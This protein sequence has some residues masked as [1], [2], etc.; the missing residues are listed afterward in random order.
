[1]QPAA[2]AGATFSVIWW[3]GKFHGVMQ[4]TTPIGSRTSSE[5]PTSRASNG[6]RPA[7]SA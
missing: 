6:Y 4:P 7:S 1:M 5:L 2:S 3:S